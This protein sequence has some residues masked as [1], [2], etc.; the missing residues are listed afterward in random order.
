VLT[1]ADADQVLAQVLK[2][3]AVVAFVPKQ[4]LTVAD[5]RTLFCG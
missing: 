1:S 4:E 5:L 2:T 3:R